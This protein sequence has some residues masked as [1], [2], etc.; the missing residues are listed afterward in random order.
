[1]SRS[2]LK[3]VF[4]SDIGVEAWSQVLDILE[5]TSRNGLS[6][7]LLRYARILILKILQVFLRGRILAC[8]VL[9]PLSTVLETP[10]M[11]SRI[12]RVQ[13]R[14]GETLLFLHPHLFCP[15]TVR[16]YSDVIVPL[17]SSVLQPE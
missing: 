17:V 7:R 9:E 13:G 10:L 12:L 4:S 16:P 11:A 15:V 3:K 2:H 5:G 1:M 8:L 14:V 6:T